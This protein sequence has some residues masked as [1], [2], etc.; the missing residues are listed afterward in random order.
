MAGEFL[1]FKDYK[2]SL[3]EQIKSF[4]S[5]FELLKTNKVDKKDAFAKIQTAVDNIR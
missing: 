1:D 2:S 5:D 4:V 3:K